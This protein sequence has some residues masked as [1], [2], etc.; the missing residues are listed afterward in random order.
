MSYGILQEDYQIISFDIT[1]MYSNIP[2]ELV[3]KS[4]LERWN[5]ICNN[6]SILLHEFKI[7]ISIIL[8]STFFKFNDVI[9]EQIFGLPMGS[10]LSPILGDV[11]IQDLECNI[12]NTIITHIPFYY[13]Y[14]D[15]IVF[16]TPN[17]LINIILCSFNSYHEH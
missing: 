13:R 2:N 14:V 9:N 10:P 11:I 16:A 12:F 17:N 15:D 3:L 6:T 8:K 4:V 1:S 7:A 5:L